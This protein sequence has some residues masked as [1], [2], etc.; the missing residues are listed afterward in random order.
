M[1]GI[2]KIGSKKEK[3]EYDFIYI[4]GALVVSFLIFLAMPSFF[5]LSNE[6]LTPE[7]SYAS[8]LFQPSKENMAVN[9]LSKYSQLVVLF[10]LGLFNIEQYFFK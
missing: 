1:N 6:K 5:L 8:T 10:G 2:R 7:R 9:K 3:G 4:C